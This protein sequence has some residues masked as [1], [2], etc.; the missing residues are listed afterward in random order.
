[1]SHRQS[2]NIAGHVH[3]LTFSCFRRQRFLAGEFESGC[4]A[5]SLNAARQL[6]HFELWAY[7]IMP[8]HVHLLIRP[9]CS[10]Y[11]M[12]TIFRRI[13]EPASRRILAAWRSG[14]ARS[15]RS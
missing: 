3:F 1:M 5:E 2:F 4:F 8:E 12:A 11:K 13:K 15:R 10:G 7:V 14:V 6:E 9:T